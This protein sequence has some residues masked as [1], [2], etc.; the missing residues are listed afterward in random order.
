M[1]LW[2]LSHH[3]PTFKRETMLNRS[4]SVTIG[5]NTLT[6]RAAHSLSKEAC[7]KRFNTNHILLSSLFGRVE[8]SDIEDSRRLSV[9]ILWCYTR[10]QVMSLLITNGRDRFLSTPITKA[11][12]GG[13]YDPC[14]PPNFTRRP[15]YFFLALSH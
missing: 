15:H 7:D 9:R 8:P 11:S 1:R 10:H 12:T 6:H 4:D 13:H 2:R 3:K 14:W 5:V